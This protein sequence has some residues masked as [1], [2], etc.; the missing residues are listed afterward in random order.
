MLVAV[1][2]SRRMLLATAFLTG[3]SGGIQLMACNLLD[4]GPVNNE[5]GYP[6]D[7]GDPNR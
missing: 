6:L 7:S 3:D 4:V 1:I 2:A 5:E